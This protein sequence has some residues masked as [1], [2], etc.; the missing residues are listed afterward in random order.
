MFLNLKSYII[1]LS[2]HDEGGF[3]FPEL[4]I[5]MGIVVIM[6]GFVTINLLRAQSSS[7]LTTTLD[8][9]TSDIRNQQIKAMTGDT[10]GRGVP[11]SYG[12]HLESDRYVL[13]HGTSYDQSDTSNVTVP[14]D[15]SITLV[16]DLF[17]SGDIVFLQT[18]GEV[19]N[20]SPGANSFTLQTVTSN[21]SQ[22]ITL[23]KY[24]VITSVQ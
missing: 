11:D 9:L 4:I 12:I 15:P 18:S 3:T 17:Q 13:F 23:N 6:L 24:G 19:R 16:S 8:T 2:R 10:E 5:V 22:T 20:F 7:S 14:I 1:N 21:Q